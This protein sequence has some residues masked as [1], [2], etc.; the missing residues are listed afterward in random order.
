MAEN[1]VLVRFCLRGW[2]RPLHLSWI[3]QFAHISVSALLP[4]H[5][6][7][8]AGIGDSR[9]TLAI[10]RERGRQE[11]CASQSYEQMWVP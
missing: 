11:T 3:I 6:R 7:H 8:I 5:C 10:E 2:L 4:S 1:K 9:A